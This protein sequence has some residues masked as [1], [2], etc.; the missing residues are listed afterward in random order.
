MEDIDVRLVL[1]KFLRKWHFFAISVGLMLVV[2][3]IYLRSTEKKYMVQASVQ[4]KEQNLN[5]KG[6]DDKKFINGLELLEN[7]AAIE[8]EIG[9]LTS[10]SVVKQTV[11]KLENYTNIYKTDSKLKFKPVEKFFSKE[12]YHQDIEIR[13]L[14]NRPQLIDAPIQIS[15]LD[16][17]TFLVEVQEHNATVYDYRSQKPLGIQD[18]VIFSQKGVIGKPFVSPLI[19]FMLVPAKTREAEFWNNDYYFVNHSVKD[20]A[21]SY[22][23]KLSVA[24]I[25]EKSNIVSLSL[26]GTVP[27]K[28]ALFLNML[29]SV[30]VNNDL[31]KRNQLGMNALSFID[32]Q[33]DKVS[34]TL[35]KVE[36]S[37]E[38]FRSQSNVID[39]GV[40]AQSYTDLLNQLEEKQVDRKTQ[41]MY[42]QYIADYL[43]RS[44][45]MDGVVTPSAAGINDPSLTKL[46]EDLNALNKERVSVAYNSNA[47]N[48]PVLKVLDQKISNTKKTLAENV[49]GLI[50][51]SRIA[52]N[53]NQHR[54]DEVKGRINQLPANE[55]NLNTIQ[56]K[57]QLNDDVYKYLLQKRAEASIAIAS[58]A[59]DKSIVDQARQVGSKPVSPNATLTY[60]MAIMLGLI[61]PA[62][63]LSVKDY[64]HK[65]IEGEDQ[66][67]KETQLSVVASIMFD[68]NSKKYRPLTTH[69][70]NDSAFQEIRHYIRFKNQQVIAVTSMASN[71]GKTY[72]AINLAVA[73]A[74]AG[75]KTL[76]IDTDFYQSD[77]GT[78]FNLET[79]PGLIDFLP[80]PSK[81]VVNQ[82]S[83][84]SL[85]VISAGQAS[86][87]SRAA[88]LRSSLEKLLAELRHTYTY[89]IIDTCPVGLISDYLLFASCVDYTL[90]VVRSDVTKRENIG[91]LNT[92]L[93]RHNLK[94]K[95]ALVYNATRVSKELTNYY[96]KI[97]S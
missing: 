43:A 23:Q 52:L 22:Q 36:G 3:F 64:M 29:S 73:F 76:L 27:E 50:Q 51:S 70:Y 59:P 8:D 91:R 95:S 24:P 80:D 2:A 14:K 89:I 55:R 90:V 58:S 92:I 5:E 63:Y 87:S 85:D 19:S 65:R 31:Q 67:E 16:K 60:L 9:I 20:L 45:T 97:A 66:L 81:V 62:G 25:A 17:H 33:I 13:L 39:V 69:P 12:V 42:Y 84:P 28:E 7:N 57:F 71:E 77:V 37:L 44:A 72:C 11:E 88:F 86:E 1:A 96:K 68:S 35:N 47:D 21:E 74:K 26:Q 10:Y 30:Y 78:V 82:T 15:F 56:R 54:V 46:L 48:N 75:H 94:N 61:F 93:N 18:E 34:N 41:L 83:I 79:A 32:N 38:K 6:S 53:E 40:S 49:Q 4:L